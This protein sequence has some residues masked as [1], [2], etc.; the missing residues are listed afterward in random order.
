MRHPHIDTSS[1]CMRAVCAALVLLLPSV[2]Q[3]QSA[4]VKG[5]MRQKL[6]HSQAILAAVVT[7][8]WAELQRRSEAIIKITNDPAWSVMKTPEY[9]SQ[10]QAFVRSVQEIV[11]AAKRHDLDEAPVAYMSMTLR[12]VQCHRYVARM[13]TA[14]G[15]G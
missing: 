2:V 9:A 3:A 7:S 1:A 12:C 5:L 11:D 15:R 8:N 4:A 10:S 14:S 13:R 6:D